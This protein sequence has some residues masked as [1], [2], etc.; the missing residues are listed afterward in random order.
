MIILPIYFPYEI[1]S[2]LRES[3]SFWK[4]NL[5]SK[6]QKKNTLRR[7]YNNITI[8]RSCYHRETN[9]EKHPTCVVDQFDVIFISVLETI[10]SKNCIIEFRGSTSKKKKMKN[11]YNFYVSNRE[12][13]AQ[14]SRYNSTTRHNFVTNSTSEFI[15]IG[16]ILRF[17]LEHVNLVLR[18]FA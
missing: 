9:F 18:E 6:V 17:N 3:R 5:K 11:E 10:E 16:S 12:T 4:S 1:H 15:S 7:K 8:L 13:G 2:F 14:I